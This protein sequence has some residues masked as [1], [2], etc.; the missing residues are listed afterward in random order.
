MMHRPVSPQTRLLRDVDLA[1]D[2]CLLGNYNTALIYYQGILQEAQRC[3]ERSDAA[4]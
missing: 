1:R 2:C 4:S 3:I